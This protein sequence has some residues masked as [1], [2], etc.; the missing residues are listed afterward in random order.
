VVVDKPTPSPFAQ[1][2]TSLENGVK[3]AVDELNSQHGTRLRIKL[4]TKT[5]D[6]Q[7]AAAVSQKLRAAG[8]AA[9]ILPCDTD[10]EY[11]LAAAAAQSGVLMLAPCD[12]EPSAGARYANYWAV[13]MGANAEAAGIA[14]YMVY[15]RSPQY[16]G[17]TRIFIVTAP[18]PRYVGSLTSY[19]RTAAPAQHVTIVGSATVPLAT[20]S[21]A[22]LAR[23]IKGANA[24]QGIF[25][26]LPPPYV[27][28]LVAGLAANGVLP[29]QVFGTAAMDTPL[30][31][32]TKFPP[33]QALYFASYG[34][35]RDD[36][37]AQRFA[38]DYE[39]RVGQAVVG[40]FPG[41][42][43]E[44]VRLYTAAVEKARSATPT[45]VDA[46]LTAGLKLPG[47]GLADRTYVRDGDH[48]PLGEVGISQDQAGRIES[49]Y[50]S[51]PTDVPLS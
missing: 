34:F 45:A 25:T 12:P 30:T 5:L 28:R 14:H 4:V 43:L 13:G 3:V 8:A 42:G 17:P 40:G 39:H 50:A 49:L 51:I 35:L 38:G 36:A 26:A 22:A 41:L 18:S 10:S 24:T 27:D 31:L 33:G 2:N 20:H 23:K 46:V 15:N 9:L 21:Y 37:A 7:S 11:P 48:S 1:Q 47:V 32:S 6:G 44:T 19:F 16:T 29:P